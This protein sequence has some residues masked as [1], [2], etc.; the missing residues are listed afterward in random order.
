MSQGIS[1][2]K[3][4]GKRELAVL[5]C[6]AKGYSNKEIGKALGIAPGTVKSHMFHILSKLGAHNRIE[7]LIAYGMQLS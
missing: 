6:V 1:D 5:E 2:V 3:A 4:L 7:A